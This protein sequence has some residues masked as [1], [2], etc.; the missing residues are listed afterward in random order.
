MKYMFLTASKTYD[1]LYNQCE[2]K[3]PSRIQF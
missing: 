2:Y 1:V 3:L